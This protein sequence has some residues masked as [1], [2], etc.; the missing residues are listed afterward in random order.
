MIL[1]K[2][3]QLFFS[4]IIFKRRNKVIKEN[5]VNFPRSSPFPDVYK[6]M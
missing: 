3:F 5:L 4:I 2:L 1:N 6:K